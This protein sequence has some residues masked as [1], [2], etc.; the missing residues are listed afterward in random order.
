MI[1]YLSHPEVEVDPNRD[2][3]LWRLSDTGRTRA[4]ALA[5]Q[6]A[7]I[8]FDLIVASAETKA[9]ETAAILADAWDLPLRIRPQM[10]ENDRSATG[11]LPPD[12][13]EA[14]ADAFFAEPDAS[15]RGWE[16]A[17]AAQDRIVGEVDSVLSA[18]P[19]PTPLFVGHGGVGTLLYCHLI[20]HPIDRVH[21]QPPGGGG[22]WFAWTQGMAPRHGWQPMEDLPAALRESA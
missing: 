22:N 5:H 2:V 21:D 10:H 12:Q 19:T 16:T 6:C 9:V 4:V 1:C 20:G 18:T 15:F 11:F 3:P 8:P 14:A 13:F 7:Q 17:R